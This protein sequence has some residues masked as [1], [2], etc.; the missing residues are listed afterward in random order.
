MSTTPTYTMSNADCKAII[1]LYRER[2]AKC[3][4]TLLNECKGIKDID[5]KIKH[6]ALSRT[7]ENKK[8]RHQWR[9]SDDD[10]AEFSKQLLKKNAKARIINAKSFDDLLKVVAGCKVKGVG[11]LAIY[12]VAL[13]LGYDRLLPGKIHLHA[14]TR[15]GAKNLFGADYVRGKG[16]LERT[17]FPKPFQGLEC[18]ELENL[19]CV[20]KDELAK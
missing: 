3:P 8:H 5:A 19:L 14:G 6:A 18:W 13:R 11:P 12:D 10:L 15:V 20:C 9:L 2:V 1:R 17:D 7:K 16:V 4:D